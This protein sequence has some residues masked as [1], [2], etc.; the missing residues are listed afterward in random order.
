MAAAAEPS[1][2]RYRI[3]HLATLVCYMEGPQPPNTQVIKR[4]IT[5]YPGPENTGTW[6]HLWKQHYVMYTL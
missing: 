1:D 2:H 5:L 6:K 3:V 4:N